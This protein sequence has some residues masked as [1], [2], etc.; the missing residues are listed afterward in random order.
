MLRISAPYCAGGTRSVMVDFELFDASGQLL[1]KAAGCRFRAAYLKRNTLN[2]VSNWRMLPWLTPTHRM[3][4]FRIWLCPMRFH[5]HG[6]YFALADER[7]IWFK[8]T[9]PLSEVL[10]LSFARSIPATGAAATR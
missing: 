7:Q 8:Q 4:I 5:R 6:T 10:V 2:K 3:T 1:A 9:L